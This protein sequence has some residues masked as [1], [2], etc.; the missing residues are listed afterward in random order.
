MA[1]RQEFAR[2]LHSLPGTDAYF[3]SGKI[4]AWA[5][6]DIFSTTYDRMFSWYNAGNTRLVDA[7]VARH[8]QGVTTPAIIPGYEKE[9]KAKMYRPEIELLKANLDRVN[10]DI[11]SYANNVANS[12]AQNPLL[13]DTLTRQRDE[14][15]RA[16]DYYLRLEADLK[17]QL[18]VQ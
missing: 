5:R 12:S 11:D 18:G 6:G 16:L 1:A 2:Y 10:S 9:D 8:T 7:E 17:K 13:I 3:G 14:T 15:A 4:D